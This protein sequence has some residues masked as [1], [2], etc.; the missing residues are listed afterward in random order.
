MTLTDLAL[1]AVLAGVFLYLLHLVVLAAVREGV[2]QALRPD[3]LAEQPDRD[4]ADG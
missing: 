1:V 4:Q 2:R 3:L